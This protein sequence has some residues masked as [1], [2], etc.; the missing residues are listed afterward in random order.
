MM[1]GYK[2]VMKPRVDFSCLK[3]YKKNMKDGTMIANFE[4]VH[5]IT[6]PSLEKIRNIAKRL[7]S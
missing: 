4:T 5:E 3:E 6:S 7:Q 1:K 2:R